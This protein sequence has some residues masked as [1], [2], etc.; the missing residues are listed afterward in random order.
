MVCTCTFYV[1][2]AVMIQYMYVPCT[3]IVCT[4]TLTCTTYIHY[5]MLY[6]YYSMYMSST[7]QYCS[8]QKLK[9]NNV[10]K[11]DWT[12]YMLTTY[13][14]IQLLNQGTIQKEEPRFFILMSGICFV[15]ILLCFVNV[16]FF[17][18]FISF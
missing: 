11:V 5:V 16:F 1:P 7:V 10:A 6:M 17:F 14:Y 4:C 15:F 13:T 18:W 8:A 12:W 3:C 2:C 9:N